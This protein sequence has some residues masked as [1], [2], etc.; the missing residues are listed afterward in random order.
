MKFMKWVMIAG[1]WFIVIGAVF[2]FGQ[3][4]AGGSIVL[5]VA[6]F[7]PIMILAGIVY[8]I[9]AGVKKLRGK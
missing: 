8:V 4:D 1:F 9:L 7:L 3:P 5:S 6:K 2:A